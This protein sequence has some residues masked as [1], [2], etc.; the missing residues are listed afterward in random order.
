M[1]EMTPEDEDRLGKLSGIT[2]HVEAAAGAGCYQQ[3]VKPDTAAWR[4]RHLSGFET[5]N[6]YKP[7]VFCIER[8]FKTYGCL[9]IQTFT[10]SYVKKII[11]ITFLLF[12]ISE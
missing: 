1:N 8:I 5:C 12:T 3:G 2:E 11:L 6:R 4:L 7:Q 9:F 10:G